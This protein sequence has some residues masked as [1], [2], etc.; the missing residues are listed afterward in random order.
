M[1]HVLQIAGAVDEDDCRA[2][3]AVIGGLEHTRGD[4]DAVAR[5]DH[6]DGRILPRVLG[7]LGGGRGGE[8]LEVLVGSVLLD[9]EVGR[10]VGVGVDVGDPMFVGREDG[11]VLAGG[12]GDAGERAAVAG[13]FVEELVGRAVFAGDQV[14]L[15]FVARLA[16]VEH[17][18][19]AGGEGARLAAFEGDGVEMGVAGSFADGSRPRDRS[20]S[21]RGCWRRLAGRRPRRRH[22][23]RRG[24]GSCRWRGRGRRAS[25]LCCRRRGRR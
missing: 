7:E 21:S 17:F 6:D 16:H 3:L 1:I 18:P 9:V 25:G 24:C 19:I 12:L 20:S 23:C 2:A 15:G 22:G 13:H 5:G 11:G 4:L 10:L 8:A 14:E